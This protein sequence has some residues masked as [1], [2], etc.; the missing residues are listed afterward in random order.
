M[1]NIAFFSGIAE[2]NSALSTLISPY[3]AT[4][5]LCDEHTE[6]HC[7][8]LISSAVPHAH[9]ITIQSGELHKNIDSCEQIWSR[10]TA[11]AADRRSLLIN[12]G[13]GVITDMGGFA[14]SCYKR[15]ID[16]INI[17]T[18]LLAMIDAS[19]G[20]KTGID[21]HGLKNQIGLFSEAR[22]VLICPDFLHT[23]D[24]RQLRSGLAEIIKHYLIAD[25]EAFKAFDSK[26]DFHIDL[27]KKAIDIKSKIVSEDPYEIGVRKILNFGHTIGHA[28]E[29][30]MLST[31]T[32][33][34]HGEAI[35]IGMAIETLI[36]GQ[37]K[38]LTQDEVSMIIG[39]L[40]QIF[41][42]KSLS[43]NSFKNLLPLIMQDKK[44]NKG[45]VKMAL[46]DGIG[47]CMMDVSVDD[48]EI[49]LAIGEYNNRL[50]A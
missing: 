35:A 9:L 15:G 42:L 20:G 12:L 33:L 23:L 11:K 43:P 25:G 14:A 1:E 22:S 29:A 5:I 32:P 21:F 4:F 18:T 37:K 30:Q 39:K 44:N 8:P 48:H 38:L 49:A 34:L 19:V 45:V 50:K 31:D 13:G 27:I 46:I 16:F 2:L 24:Q 40:T 17:P 6:K 28:L 47:R 36:A 41:D 10:L 26:S 3:S 7:L